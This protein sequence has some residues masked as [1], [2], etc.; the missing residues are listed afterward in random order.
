MKKCFTLMWTM[1]LVGL[2]GLCAGCK[3]SPTKVVEKWQ[4]AVGKG[5]N[6]EATKYVS[7][8][9]ASMV[10]ELLITF[11][12]DEDLKKSK[13]ISDFKAAKPGNEKINGDSATVDFDGSTL[14][15]KKIDGNWKITGSKNK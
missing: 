14:Q 13:D 6:S 5:D 8:A 10:T 7:G 4:A 12:K 9:E 15:L 1:L 3:D 2:L 11:V